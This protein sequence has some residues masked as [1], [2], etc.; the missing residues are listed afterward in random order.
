[1]K[2][3]ITHAS[4][5]QAAKPRILVIED[6][7]ALSRVLSI[8]LKRAGF[9]VYIAATG[10]HGLRLADEQNCNLIL[11]DIDLPDIRGFEVCERVK[12]NPRLRL[13]PIIL[14]SGRLAEG[15]EARALKVGAADYLSKPFGAETIVSKISAHIRGGKNG[16]GTT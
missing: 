8:V 7:P 11:S 1:M 4:D 13:I 3:Q 5:S 14:M 2:A 15:N 16:N 10:M 6:E 9:E 12:Q